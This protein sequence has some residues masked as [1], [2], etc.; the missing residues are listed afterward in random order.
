MLWTNEESLYPTM[1]DLHLYEKLLFKITF[2]SIRAIMFV[3][4][5]ITNMK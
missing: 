3:M 1:N 5:I 4:Y 2:D